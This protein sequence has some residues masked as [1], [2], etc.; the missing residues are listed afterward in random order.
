L[1][2]L[3]KNV[4]PHQR[5]D[6]DRDLRVQRSS[7]MYSFRY[8]TPQGRLPFREGPSMGMSV[9]V[10]NVP[11][12]LT[13]A[14]ECANAFCM[15]VLCLLEKDFHSAALHQR[16]ERSEPLAAPHQWM[17]VVPVFRTPL[18][19]HRSLG[20]TRTPARARQ[21]PCHCRSD[22]LNE[23]RGCHIYWPC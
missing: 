17:A 16:L 11:A 20:Q 23:R 3:P 5:V 12:L 2:P 10:M 7:I 18:A 13:H 15:D 9:S 4:G 1:H 21:K 8:D 6:R 19:T 22:T 14:W